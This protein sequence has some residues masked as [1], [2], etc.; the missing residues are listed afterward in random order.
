MAHLLVKRLH[1]MYFK[2][3]CH[4]PWL[5][6]QVGVEGEEA[7]E[8]ECLAAAALAETAHNGKGDAGVAGNDSVAVR[9]LE[10]PDLTYY[11]H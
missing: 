10:V 11:W 5:F 7:V 9:E 3:T 2:N 6:E 4:L 8:E 1:P